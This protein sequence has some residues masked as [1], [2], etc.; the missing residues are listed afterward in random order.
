MSIN[1]KTHEWA[2]SN[3]FDSFYFPETTSTND[4]AKA[5]F[6]KKEQ[7]FALYTADHQ[8]QGRGRHDRSWQNM[9]GGE[10]LLSTWSFRWGQPMQP[11]FPALVGLALYDSLK[12]MKNGLPLRL[13]APND[14]YLENGKLAGLL[15]EASQQGTNCDIFIGLGLNVFD[16]PEIDL[17]TS[18]LC[19][20][21]GFNDEMW[22]EFCV[23]LH[24]NFVEAV[25]K[26]ESTQLDRDDQDRLLEALNA[27]R[28]K[29]E[30]ILEISPQC[31]LTTKAGQI[32]WKDL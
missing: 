20:Y 28:P 26:G 2:K 9:S 12:S 29:E 24:L 19:H 23:Q 3:N 1:L 31:D 8:S 32:S 10:I 17:P 21:V 6:G 25:V 14:I 30:Q 5:E 18:A 4:V 13:K 11:I 7:E 16:R 27:G 22:N 15:I